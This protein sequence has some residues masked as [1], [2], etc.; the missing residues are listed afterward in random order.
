MGREKINKNVGI[1]KGSYVVMCK[2]LILLGILWYVY[3]E[4]RFEFF[5]VFRKFV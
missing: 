1:D 5:W 2:G 3:R 4:V